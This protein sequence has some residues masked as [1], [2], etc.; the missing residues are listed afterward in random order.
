MKHL[1]LILFGLFSLRASPAHAQK[2]VLLQDRVDQH[3]FNYDE[4][5]VL[6][7]S[8]RLLT[9]ADVTVE[10]YHSR[11]Y[12]NTAFSPSGTNNKLVYWYRI[13]VKHPESS[14][15]RWVIEFFDQTIDSLTF[16]A[17]DTSGSYQAQ[18][19]GDQLSFDKR[20]RWHK[21]LIHE[22]EPRNN[23][24]VTYY[25]RVT[26]KQKADVL[27]VLRSESWLFHYA[28]DEYFFFG[29]FY[30]M[31]LVF[32]FYNL[33]MF[34]AVRETHYLYYIIYLVGVGLYEMSAD[35]IGFQ[36]LWPNQPW[37][38]YYASGIFLYL[39]TM[40][41]LV[42]SGSVLNLRSE[43]RRF[44]WL[45]VGVFVF[46]TA[47]LI[48]SLT[49]MPHWFNFRFIEVIPFAAVYIASIRGYF[50]KSYS[51][52]RYLVL[53][54]SFVLFGITYKVFQ[55]LNIEWSPLGELSHYSLGISFIGE[56]LLLSLAISD[57]IS[58][59]RQEKDQ[60]QA[61]TIEQLHENQRLKDNLNQTLEEQV[62]AKTAEL[63]Q[64]TEFIAAQNHKLELA[65][66]QLEAQAKEIEEI[67][68][69][70]ARDN[71]QLQHDVAE[72]KEARVLSK[73][74]DY[75]E[76]CA[77]HPNDD[78]WMQFLSDVKWQKGFTCRK[79][80]G[81]TYSASR[82]AYG[83]R[84]TKCGYEE[85]VTAYTLLQNTRLPLSKALYMIYLVYNSQG[86]IS[87]HKLSEILGIRQST[88]WSYS[89]RIK[90]LLKHR[91]DLKHAP[92]GWKSII[93]TE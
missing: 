65:N 35:G 77:M 2:P 40:A 75:E 26:S 84:C 79:C 25:I 80:R 34:I 10:P 64:K 86:T 72:I 53:A 70:L 32:T 15:R 92:E 9:I 56:M 8:S 87:S 31:I 62:K 76:F 51:P 4:L 20:V 21:N 1:A 60:A 19:F 46:R 14:K 28:L 23:Q 24:E 16:Y 78:S 48:L 17:P 39:A 27:V 81:T 36:Y 82:S 90:D 83:R 11:F 49:V 89:A 43:H 22:L 59:L 37:F 63:V 12:E 3:I 88:C 6:E 66:E 74:V 52:A 30:G 18:L 7:D 44:F 57:K 13:K 61:N 45:F 73:E 54:Y 42:F 50:V 55:Y 69:L 41:A 71:E 91:K 47:F 58:L 85:S 33:L 38:N 5:E 29:I 67:N 68:I 93:L